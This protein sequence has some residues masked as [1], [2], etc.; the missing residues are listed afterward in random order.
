MN[1]YPRCLASRSPLFWSAILFAM[2]V[3][4]TLSWSVAGS[5]PSKPLNVQAAVSNGI[6]TIVWGAPESNGGSPIK[7]YVA[8]STDGAK[9][10][11][12]GP[13]ARRCSIKALS[14]VV[15][16]FR[17]YAVNKYG[18]GEGSSESNPTVASKTILNGSCGTSHGIYQSILPSAS[19]DLCL[20]GQPTAPMAASDGSFSWLCVGLGSG[21]TYQCKSLPK[22]SAGIPRDMTPSEKQFQSDLLLK[23]IP[24]YLKSPAS[25]RVIEG[26]SWVWYRSI[27]SPDRGAWTITFEGQN[28]FGVYL[29]NRGICETK[30]MPD[31]YWTFDLTAN[32]RLCH[33]Y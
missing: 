24:T 25:F 28:L 17:V 26:P 2:L 20:A 7:R 21:V 5:T 11:S 32:L 1:T 4:P 18:T 19:L 15:R 22:S 9:C 6:T 29:R 27:G 23:T 31:G 12:I 13:K 33:F 30:Y 3:F 16:V 8:I 14:E 10:S